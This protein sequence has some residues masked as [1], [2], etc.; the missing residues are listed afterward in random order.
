MS[1]VRLCNYK[2]CVDV[3]REYLVVVREI[4]IVESAA[5]LQAIIVT[6]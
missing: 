4:V 6:V 1:V 2:N 5:L 3:T